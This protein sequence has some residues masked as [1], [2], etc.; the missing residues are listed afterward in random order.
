MAELRNEQVIPSVKPLP[1]LPDGPRRPEISSVAPC[2]LM[3]L[4]ER[5]GSDKGLKHFERHGY[6]RV[7]EAL[8]APLREEPLRILEIGLLHS[9]DARWLDHPWENLGRARGAA[10]PS[11]N[12]WSSYFPSAEVFGLDINDFT[13]VT[14]PRTRIL[15]GDM[16][17]PAALDRLVRETGGHFDIIVDDASHCSHHQQAALR[18]L[19]PELNSGGLYVIEDLHWQNPLWER[20]DAAKTQDLLLE[21]ADKQRRPVAADP[22]ELDRYVAGHLSEILFFDSLEP[23]AVLTAR[24]A[25]AILRRS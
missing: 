5:F 17:D 12:M 23:G 4:A 8:F 3:E 11:L 9:Q 15:Q 16:G 25:L 22:G 14:L 7:Y 20:P 19:F 18:R 24:D 1:L 2:G 21:L 6:A 13:A 10:A